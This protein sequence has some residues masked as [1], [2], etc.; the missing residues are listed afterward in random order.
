MAKQPEQAGAMG[1]PELPR[2]SLFTARV[3]Y[4][5]PSVDAGGYKSVSD[6]RVSPLPGGAAGLKQIEQRFLRIPAIKPCADQGRGRVKGFHL[7]TYCFDYG[8]ENRLPWDLLR[9]QRAK[10]IY[11]TGILTHG[12]D[13]VLASQPVDLEDRNRRHAGCG[14]LH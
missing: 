7:D 1:T 14:F 4:P 5:A 12:S 6:R 11:F 3:S 13:T 10:K 8:S 9:E 2:P